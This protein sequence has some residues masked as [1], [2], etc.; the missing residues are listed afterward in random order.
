MHVPR[1]CACPD[2]SG[3]PR[4]ECAPP[5]WASSN[6]NWGHAPRPALSFSPGGDPPEVAAW[7]HRVPHP[8][9][10]AAPISE[11]SM[12]AINCPRELSL[13]HLG[14]GSYILLGGAPA[15]HGAASCVARPWL[16]PLRV[17]LP[18]LPSWPPPHPPSTNSG[19][20]IVPP[21]RTHSPTS[22]RGGWTAVAAMAQ[23]IEN[24]PLT[25]HG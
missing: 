19:R 6:S 11:L 3:G 22:A 4:T 17:L 1:V 2:E 12:L 25:G 9:G 21:P 8:T 18:S 15:H 7:V 16:F 14:L 23:D 20:E 10:W 5:P 13:D 24:A